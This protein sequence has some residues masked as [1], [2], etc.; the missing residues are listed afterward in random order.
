MAN[1]EDMLEPTGQEVPLDDDGDAPAP[2]TYDED[3]P[4]LVAAF[5]AHED[6]KKALK[7]IADRVHEDFKKDWDATAEYRERKVKD[8]SMFAGVLPAK[9]F[10]YENCANINVP[11]MLESISRLHFRML[12]E[13]YGDWMNVVRF[14]PVGGGDRT[15]AD[16][17][18][19]HTNWQFRERLADVR[20]QASRGLLAFLVF[21]DVTYHSYWDPDAGRNQH[22]M[23]TCDDFVIPFTHVTTQPDYSDVPRRTRIF[24]F[25]RHQLEAY[26][27]R[28]SGVDDVIDKKPPAWDDEP[29]QPLATHAAE[30][31][32]VEIEDDAGKRG[33]YKIIQQEAWLRLPNQ[34][35]DRF[36]QVIMDPATKNILC[37]KVHE[38]VDWQDQLRF[39]KEI[40]ERDAYVQAYQHHQQVLTERE[41]LRGQMA[42]LQSA[43]MPVPPDVQ[44]SLMEEPPAPV[45][46]GW[47]TDPLGFNAVPE[48]PKKV[49]IHMFAHGVCIE[50]LKGSLGLSYG[51][52]EADYNRAANILMDQFVDSATMA[53][54]PPIFAAEGVSLPEK[55]GIQPGKITPLK[56]VTSDEL[57]RAL[58]PFPS[59]PGNDQLVQ[60]V[61][62]LMQWGQT[63]MQAP[64]VLSG[65]PGKSGETYRGL[66]ARVEQAT[67]QI[68]VIA[69]EFASTWRQVVRHNSKLN[70]LFLGDEEFV[71]VTAE[72]MERAGLNMQ[73]PIRVTRDM[74]RRNYQ[75]EMTTDARFI[76]QTQRV[77]EADEMVQ[78]AS[79]PMLAANPA[80]AY[81]AIK[82]A[83][84][85]RGRS[86]MAK[87]LGPPPPPPQQ[88][89]P[90]P[91]M[92]PGMPP[93]QPPSGGAPPTGGA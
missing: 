4:N 80:F 76:S 77:A 3:E 51:Q 6:G 27:D 15:E 86:D 43:G 89:G 7:E 32:G 29:D 68:S 49:P 47:M 56:G 93:G 20:R 67:T 63:S 58:Y 72:A 40:A 45:A 52:I 85:A 91:G 44:N 84:E 48:A 37:L 25:E 1:V 31:A 81:E 82:R 26:R 71:A 17:L 12:S 60:L 73:Q 90:P 83:L 39:D 46:P 35:R 9:S 50:P 42:V 57:Q 2:F 14:L 13:I 66:Q 24:K 88:F 11:V 16:A 23:L 10:P 55:I 28:W 87:F 59:K 64:G 38:E 74:Y 62:M 18:T 65:E 22:D 79:H 53:N 36:C 5:E 33:S 34:D 69:R 61:N 54:A 41:G 78:M 75:V 21:G 30:T 70:S 92:A 8:W 19:L